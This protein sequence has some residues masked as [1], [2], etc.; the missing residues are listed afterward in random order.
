MV[1]LIRKVK[2]QVRFSLELITRDALKVP[3][4]TD[5]YW[6]TMPDVP[7]RDLART[8]RFVREHS[9]QDL[10][11]V[12]TLPLERQVALEDANVAASLK[13]AREELSL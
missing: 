7:G 2:P 4:L 10:Q 5:Q 13:Y 9:S 1:E 11:E 6:A 3:C 8:L 12:S